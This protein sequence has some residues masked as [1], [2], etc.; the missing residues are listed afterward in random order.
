MP[1]TDFLAPLVAPRRRA[2]ATVAVLL[3]DAVAAH[4]RAAGLRVVVG[5]VNGVPIRRTVRDIGDG[6]L[7]LAVG[8]GFLADAGA[9]LGEIVEVTLDFDADPDAVRIPAELGAALAERP[10][11][12]AAFDGLTASRQRGVCME[13]ERGR[14]AEVR[15][16]RAGRAVAGL[17]RGVRVGR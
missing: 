2:M 4:C 17:L 14:S 12:R 6:Q 5:A 15:A 9:A 16:R 11:A 7:G 8:K 13:V 10:E 3:P 1:P